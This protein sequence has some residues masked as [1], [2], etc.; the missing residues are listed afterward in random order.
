MDLV[1]RGVNGGHTSCSRRNRRLLIC[2]L[3]I[4]ELDHLAHKNAFRISGVGT[5]QQQHISISF[6]LKNNLGDLPQKS[7]LYEAESAT[8]APPRIL[9]GENAVDLVAKL[10]ILKLIINLL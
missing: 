1:G 7:V 8:S 6:Q 4:L 2:V 10:N 9:P 5:C 3:A